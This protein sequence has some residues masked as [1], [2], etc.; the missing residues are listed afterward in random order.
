MSADTLP[1]WPP[2]DGSRL[3]ALPA[4]GALIEASAGTGKTYQ[5]EGLILRLVAEEGLPIESLLVI[6]FTKAATAELRGRVRQRLEHARAALAGELDVGKDDVL[7]HLLSD[8]GQRGL[9]R[10]RVEDALA[11]YDQAPVSTIHSFCQRALTEHSLAAGFDP[12]PQV[13]TDASDLL[14]RLVDDAMGAVAART[15]A[16]ECEALAQR[17]WN[18][19]ALLQVAKAVTAV[20]AGRLMPEVS[21]PAKSLSELV[22]RVL[23]GTQRRTT[24][25]RALLRWL[26]T[27]DGA[28][29]LAAWRAIDNAQIE[30]WTGKSYKNKFCGGQEQI[31]EIATEVLYW[32][33]AD[34]ATVQTDKPKITKWVVNLDSTLGIAPSTFDSLPFAPFCRGVKEVHE[35]PLAWVLPEFAAWIRDAMPTARAEAGLL[36]YDGM[37]AELADRLRAEDAARAQPLREKLRARYRAALVDEFQDTDA[38]QWDILRAVFLESPA[39]KL[40]VVGDPKQA[41]YRFRGANLGVYLAAR[42]DIAARG[43]L[44]A[45]LQTNHRADRPL[46]EALNRLWVPPGEEAFRGARVKADEMKAQHEP[47]CAGLGPS[48]VLRSILE[49]DDLTL[50]AAAARQIRSMLDKSEQRTIFTDPKHPNGRPLQASDIAVLTR[51][52]RQASMMQGALGAVGVASVRNGTSSIFSTPAALW[53]RTWLEAVEAPASEGPSRQLALSPLVGWSVDRLDAALRPR[54][55]AETT[56]DDADAPAAWEALRAGVRAANTAWPKWGVSRC[57]VQLANTWSLRRRLRTQGN[58]SSLADL[59][60]LLERLHREERRARR[61]V[62]ALRAW[63]VD[64]INDADDTDEQQQREIDSGEAAVTVSTVHASKGLQYGV[65]LLPFFATAQKARPNPSGLATYSPEGATQGE[66]VLALHPKDTA[67]YIQAKTA[68]ELEL[69]QE[70]ARQIYVATTRARHKLIAWAGLNSNGAIDN[71]ALGTIFGDAI[72]G[73]LSFDAHVSVE[74]ESPLTSFAHSAPVNPQPVVVQPWPGPDA[75]T[76]WRVTSYSGMSA[77]R[78]VDLEDRSPPEDDATEGFALSEPPEP[79]RESEGPEELIALCPP[80]DPTEMARALAP[81]ALFRGGTK[82]GDLLHAIFEHLDFTA[83]PPCAKDGASLHELITAQGK[84][85][86]FT[87]DKAGSQLDLAEALVPHWLDTPLR[88]PEG[89]VK[90]S[91]LTQAQRGDELNFDLRLGA[92]LSRGVAGRVQPAAARAAL[93]ATVSATGCKAATWLREL[94][95]SLDSKTAAKAADTSEGP[96]VAGLIPAIQGML[97]GSIDL[98][99]QA[100]NKNGTQKFFVVDYKSNQLRGGAKA[101]Q[102]TQGWPLPQSAPAGAHPGSLRRWHYSA[103]NLAWGMANTG[104]HLQSLIYTV[105]LHRWLLQRVRGYSYAE[106]FGGHFYLFLRGME[107]GESDQGV[108]YDRWPEAT[109]R[110]LDAALAGADVDA[111]AKVIDGVQK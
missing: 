5:T 31:H 72:R 76:G 105:A 23:A 16:T 109:V 83:N 82:T 28:A 73:Q 44:L 4:R 107:G 58:A 27:P 6:T 86:G 92:G 70:R 9:Y 110:G 68:E 90:L 10:Q 98:A 2:K 91:Q 12:S 53:L 35:T 54:S 34:A 64:Q 94:L 51:S 52:N 85:F 75:W 80:D 50:A 95:A 56:T 1:E 111:V 32:L 77:G 108:W 17:A 46:V 84:R 99:F 40:F 87:R 104:Y 106:N 33:K 65:V 36:T 66:R 63:L 41:I 19:K 67:E 88:F 45:S 89:E 38:A 42:A 47:R 49:P 69:E 101:Q 3:A 61:G 26:S 22:E 30:N 96:P 25:A 71:P 59:R 102:I 13:H 55:G 74:E 48:V 62:S 93:N 81:G 79:S 24:A 8:I 39:H 43:G 78:G 60:Q 14:E 20:G 18:R 37:I 97:S 15:S 103:A 11:N 29:A 100:T 21:K 57:F 7:R